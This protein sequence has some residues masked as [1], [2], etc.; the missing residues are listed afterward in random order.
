MKVAAFILLAS[1]IAADLP[2]DVQY[3]LMDDSFPGTGSPI[4][5]SRPV[6]SNNVKD[7]AS[8]HLRDKS[9]IRKLEKF[10]RTKFERN[11]FKHKRVGRTSKIP[12]PGYFS[13]T[14]SQAILGDE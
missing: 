3:T 2:E 6:D 12:W 11:I 13:E 8:V 10:F 4:N 5:Y 1:T 9:D 7:F 14:N